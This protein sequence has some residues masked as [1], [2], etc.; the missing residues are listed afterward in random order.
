MGLLTMTVTLSRQSDLTLTEQLVQR[1]T[2][3][4]EQHLLPPGTRLPSVRELSL[5][6]I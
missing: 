4:I 2:E 3:R 1:F 5:I 6:H